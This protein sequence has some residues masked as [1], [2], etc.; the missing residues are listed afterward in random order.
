RDDVVTHDVFLW[1]PMN[2][3]FNFSGKSYLLERIA[4]YAGVEPA[5]MYEELER[6]EEVL[7]WMSALGV[8]SYHELSKII[9]EYYINPERVLERMRSNESV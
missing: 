3:T 8:S 5:K 1:D 4:R 9:A 7:R 2:D 6:R